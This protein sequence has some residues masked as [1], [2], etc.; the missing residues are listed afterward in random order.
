MMNR[1]N[2]LG[3]NMT[4]EFITTNYEFSHG[5][6]PRGNGGW[7]FDIEAEWP[8]CYGETYRAQVMRFGTFTACKKQ[9]REYMKGIIVNGST[10][11]RVYVKVGA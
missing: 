10:A 5:R 3:G 11:Q 1:N 7:V 2:S 4:I 6:K 8:G 9:I